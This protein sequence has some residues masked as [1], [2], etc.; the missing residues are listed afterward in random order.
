MEAIVRTWQVQTEI[1]EI[2]GGGIKAA[3]DAIVTRGNVDSHGLE[4]FDPNHRSSPGLGEGVLSQL[5]SF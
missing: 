4:I 2:V 3:R 1:S 5:R